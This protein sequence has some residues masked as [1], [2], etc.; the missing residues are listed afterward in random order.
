MGGDSLEESDKS[1]WE[2]HKSWITI[3]IFVLIILAT[4]IVIVFI[5]FGG[6]NATW[7]QVLFARGETLKQIYTPGIFAARKKTMMQG[8]VFDP[9]NEKSLDLKYGSFIH[10][11]AGLPQRCEAFLIIPNNH[12]LR[13]FIVFTCLWPAKAW[14]VFLKDEKCL[15]IQFSEGKCQINAKSISLSLAASLSI[16]TLYR[17]TKSIHIG[18]YL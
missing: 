14:N 10:F 13:V 7:P 3:L 6:L 11:F 17:Y 18:T 16:Q 15:F 4:I 8:F 9:Q 2:R 5:G 12:F 1:W